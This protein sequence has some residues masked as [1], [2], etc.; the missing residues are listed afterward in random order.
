MSGETLT[1]FYF[2]VILKIPVLAMIALLFWAARDHSEPEEQDDDGG[3]P[4]RPP[5]GPRRG[6]PHGAPPPRTE[7]VHQG[8][9]RLRPERARVID[10]G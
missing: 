5:R 10:F 7:A 9:R 3:G 6:G 1:V 4:N 8:R 2:L